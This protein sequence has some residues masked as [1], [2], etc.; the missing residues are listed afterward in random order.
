MDTPADRASRIFFGFSASLLLILALG[1]RS[2]F[3]STAR[4]ES[5]CASDLPVVAILIS[6]AILSMYFYWALR[7]ATPVPFQ[8]QL[9]SIFSNE[10]EVAM[11]NRLEAVR[12]DSDDIER[13]SD[14]WAKLEVGLETEESE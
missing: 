5:N 6:S 9:Q 4:C 10:S 12:I 2:G 7:V 14:A 8:K 13:M 3:F 1:L 11:W